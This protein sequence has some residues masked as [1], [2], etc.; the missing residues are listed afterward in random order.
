M[1]SRQIAPDHDCRPRN[2]LPA[3]SVVVLVGGHP[4]AVGGATNFVKV[5]Q[6]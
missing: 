2:F 4:I 3:G 6:L 5:M 1:V